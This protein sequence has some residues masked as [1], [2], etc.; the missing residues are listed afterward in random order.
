LQPVSQHRVSITDAHIVSPGLFVI[1]RLP[2][3]NQMDIRESVALSVLAS[4][5]GSDT[6]RL[7]RKLVLSGISRDA[8][9][10]FDAGFTGQFSIAANAAANVD[11]ARVE[12]AMAGAI[13]E[14]LEKGVTE[15][16]L[17]LER[18]DFLASVI[19]QADFQSALAGKYGTTLAL[20]QSVDYIEKSISQIKAVTV[21]DINAVARKYLVEDLKVTGESWPL[22]EVSAPVPNAVEVK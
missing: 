21:S 8:S 10:S 15:D 22:V 14:L 3:L 16:E 4:I 6:G 20:G 7:R 12:S 13:A 5:L 1:Y 9:A 17:E 11:L 2:G 19:Y 18:A